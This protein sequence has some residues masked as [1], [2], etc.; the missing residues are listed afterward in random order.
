MEA[1]TFTKPPQWV[2]I[3]TCFG[4]FFER[5]EMYIF[6]IAFLKPFLSLRHGTENAK[7]ASKCLKETEKGGCKSS[8]RRPQACCKIVVSP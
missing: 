7:S 1:K 8:W 6:L 4:N 5:L 3:G 2:Q